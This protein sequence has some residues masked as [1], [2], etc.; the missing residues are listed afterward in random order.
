[1]VQLTPQENFNL[2]VNLCQST[3]VQLYQHK[4]V[5]SDGPMPWRNNDIKQTYLSRYELWNSKGHIQFF[6]LSPQK[7]F[8]PGSFLHQI[9]LNLSH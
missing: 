4:V 6:T 1:M 3:N 5:N 9:T 7:H 2:E 8:Q